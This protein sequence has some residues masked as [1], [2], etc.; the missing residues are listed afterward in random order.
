SFPEVVGT[1]RG[2]AE[3]DSSLGGGRRRRTGG[4]GEELIIVAHLGSTETPFTHVNIQA[5]FSGY[6]CVS[7]KGC[8][9]NVTACQ[10]MANIILILI[11]IFLLKRLRGRS[12]SAV[13]TSLPLKGRRCLRGDGGRTSPGSPPAPLPIMGLLWALSVSMLT[14]CVAIPMDA[15]AGSHSL[16]TCEPITLRMCQALPYNATFMP[17]LL[18]HYDQQTAALAMEVE[19]LPPY[20]P[21]AQ[22][23][24]LHRRI[25]LQII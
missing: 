14:A 20:Q 21:P 5:P 8:M 23:S 13:V 24:V 4:A 6:I 16:F 25:C 19:Y 3:G 15:A 12:A 9:K 2:D 11:L 1:P 10:R 18:N 7:D 22:A 17:N